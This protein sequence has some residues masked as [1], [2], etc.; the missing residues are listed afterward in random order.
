MRVRNLVLVSFLASAAAYGQP[1]AP[2]VDRPAVAVATAPVAPAAASTTPVHMAVPEVS[3]TGS[4]DEVVDAAKDTID[5]VGKLTTGDVGANTKKALVWAAIAAALIKLLLA[6]LKLTGPFWKSDKAKLVI[7][8]LT[9]TLGAVAGALAS[10]V[11]GLPWWDAVIVF[12]GGPG[13]ILLTEYQK[14]IPFLAPKKG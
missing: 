3:I 10:V 8:L 1:A 6:L 5:A 11:G 14:S 13:A 9:L 12:M 2:G 4:V 7:R